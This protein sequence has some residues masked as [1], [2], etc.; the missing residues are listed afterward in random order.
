[1]PTIDLAAIREQVTV[2]AQRLLAIEQLDLMIV[3]ALLVVVIAL[4]LSSIWRNR[5]R[6]ELA[7]ATPSS[8]SGFMRWLTPAGMKSISGAQASED[9]PRPRRHSGSNKSIRV[10]TPV[11][12]VPQRALKAG[13]DPVDIARRT[14]LSRDAVAMMM[15]AAAPRPQAARATASVTK[16]DGRAASAPR[17]AQNGQAT[18]RAM[19]APGAYTQAQRV[20][21]SKTERTG[22]VGTRLNA[23]L[24]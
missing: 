7:M 24:G 21:P 14:G 23:R 16:A 5:A 20:I 8:G 9:A 2:M 19:V 17:T 6:R 4:A 18:E 12:K 13:G 11:S 15:A 22:A 10:T 1:M 3:G